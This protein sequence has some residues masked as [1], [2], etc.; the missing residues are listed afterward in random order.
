MPLSAAPRQ[1]A[2]QSAFRD[3]GKRSGDSSRR[4][5]SSANHRTQSGVHY[6]KRRG[7]GASGWQQEHKS[8][9][10]ARA[11]GS[12]GSVKRLPN[13]VAMTAHLMLIHIVSSSSNSTQVPIGFGDLSAFYFIFKRIAPEIMHAGVWF[14]VPLSDP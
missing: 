6:S 12:G 2:T 11:Q 9:V 5:P 3:G 7:V 14:A 13:E 4:S 1:A 8:G 10:T